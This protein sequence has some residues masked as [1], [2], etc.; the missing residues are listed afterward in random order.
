MCSDPSPRRGVVK[1]IMEFIP[2]MLK[3]FD[4]VTGEPLNTYVDRELT[5]PHTNP[6]V[7]PVSGEPPP[8]FL[9]GGN[10]AEKVYGM[11]V[12]DECGREIWRISPLTGTPELSISLWRL[13][14]SW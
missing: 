7:L 6:I 11:A 9:E 1:S 10:W 5:T 12:L 8:I 3:F 13:L 2:R 4:H 14:F